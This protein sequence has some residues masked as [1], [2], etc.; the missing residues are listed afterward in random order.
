MS[1]LYPIRLKSVFQAAVEAENS[2]NPSQHFHGRGNK[3]TNKA[4]DFTVALA[5]LRAELLWPEEQTGLELLGGQRELR[6]PH[7]P[8]AELFAQCLHSL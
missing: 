3:P 6:A 4:R 1:F 5:G 2:P 8:Q 7:P